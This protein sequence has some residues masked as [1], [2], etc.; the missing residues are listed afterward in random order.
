M[1]AL[2]RYGSKEGLRRLKESD[3]EI[4]T[5]IERLIQK[6]QEEN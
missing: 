6:E 5:Q 3:P 2:K 4:A 1:Q